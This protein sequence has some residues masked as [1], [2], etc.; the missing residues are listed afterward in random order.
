MFACLTNQWRVHFW[1]YWKVF[2]VKSVNFYLQ[3]IFHVWERTSIWTDVWEPTSWPHTFQAFLLCCSPGC[4]SGS[5]WNLP[6][7]EHPWASLP[8]SPSRPRV[9]VWCA[10]CQPDLSPGRSTSGWLPVSCLSLELL[11]NIRSW[12]RWLVDRRPRIPSTRLMPNSQPRLGRA[13]ASVQH[14]RRLVLITS[15]I[16]LFTS[17][18]LLFLLIYHRLWFWIRPPGFE[19]WVG[20]NIR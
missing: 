14:A 7:R 3:V 20:A 16:S 13:A 2:I 18:I 9:P 12:I 5:T 15:S 6:R 8:S 11:S 1:T 10:A 17:S 19:S 4:P